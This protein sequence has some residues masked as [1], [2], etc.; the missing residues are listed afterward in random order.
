MWEYRAALVAVHDGDTITVEIDQ[1]F[2]GRQEE[3]VRLI[4]VSAP[5]LTDLGGAQ[6]RAFTESWCRTADMAGLR[7]PLVVTTVP[8]TGREPRERRS[9]VRYLGTVRDA[10]A[11]GRTLNTELAAYLAGHPEWGPGI[12]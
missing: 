11:A 1:G 3:S 6:A 5:E 4:G 12:T 2:G 9:F 8:T 7:W 10:T